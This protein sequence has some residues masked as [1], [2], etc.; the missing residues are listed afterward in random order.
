M[1]SLCAAACLLGHIVRGVVHHK[2]FVGQSLDVFREGSPRFGERRALGTSAFI[3]FKLLVV[4]CCGI[5]FAGSDAGNNDGIDA[6]VDVVVA[7]FAC[8]FI[9][10]A[11]HLAVFSGGASL[12][13]A[14]IALRTVVGAVEER[15]QI[16]SGILSNQS[17]AGTL[18]P[19]EALGHLHH[20]EAFVLAA[21]I[22]Q[23]KTDKMPLSDKAVLH[24]FGH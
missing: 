15:L 2:Q 3:L 12:Y 20:G 18:T 1:R 5:V 9:L 8:I 16:E 7:R 24:V 13:H 10:Y 23:F 17:D 21:P 11:P 4:T 14:D 6:V 22:V 19:A